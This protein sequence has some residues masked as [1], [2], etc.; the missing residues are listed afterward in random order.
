MM[1]LQCGY[2]NAN[3]LD[4]ALHSRANAR[5]PPSSD[6]NH[7]APITR[8]S[9]LLSKISQKRSRKVTRSKLNRA[10]R[11]AD[12]AVEERYAALPPDEKKH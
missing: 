2:R 10:A 7:C 6:R 8:Q 12:K 1:C 5:R 3:L 11:E 4:V 9:W